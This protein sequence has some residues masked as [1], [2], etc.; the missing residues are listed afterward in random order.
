MFKINIDF[1]EVLSLDGLEADLNRL[2]QKAGQD[3][4]KSIHAKLVEL[5]NKEL[6]DSRRDK[7]IAAINSSQAGE[8]EWLVS[9]DS[10]AEWIEDGHCVVYNPNSPVDKIPKILTPDGYIPINKARVG[11]MVLN[12]FAEWTPILQIHDNDLF[13]DCRETW[14]EEATLERFGYKRPKWPRSHK[15]ILVRCKKCNKLR[16]TSPFNFNFTESRCPTCAS[17]VEIFTIAVVKHNINGKRSHNSI[18]LTGSHL[19]KTQNG[20]TET[21]NIKKHDSLLVPA[22]GKCL[23]SKCNAKME[24]NHD[25]EIEFKRRKVAKVRKLVPKNGFSLTRKW[26]ITVKDGASYVCNGILIHNSAFNLIKSMLSSPKAKHGKEGPYMDVPFEQN[27]KAMSSMSPQQ[28]ALWGAIKSEVNNFKKMGSDLGNPGPV[29]G[30]DGNPK[31]G[32]IGSFDVS[33][34]PNSTNAVPIGKG[35]KGSVAQGASG[36]PLLQ[37]VK[38]YQQTVKTKSGKSKTQKMYVTFRRVSGKSKPSA[39]DHPGIEGANLFD[40]AAD[41]AQ[42]ELDQKLDKILNKI[43]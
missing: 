12:E 18:V 9:L 20:W 19:V 24:P 38:V 14:D 39:W 25:G 40:K 7:Y 33:T 11:M 31:Q 41:W 2:A 34:K 23:Y 6:G 17:N 5:A 13:E 4:A 42:Q 36:I 16:E 43:K 26:D 30:K 21:R 35:P 37:G 28:Q 27:K 1:S 29:M 22:W 15:P 8:N 32:L 3:M 10:S